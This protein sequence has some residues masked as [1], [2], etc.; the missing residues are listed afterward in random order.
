M[1]LSKYKKRKDLYFRLIS[2]VH[3]DELYGECRVARDRHDFVSK[4]R[5]IFADF[6]CESEFH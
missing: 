2:V 4:K 3:T 1:F 6:G 5:K